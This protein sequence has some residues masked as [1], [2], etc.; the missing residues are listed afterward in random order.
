VVNPASAPK[1][2][3]PQRIKADLIAGLGVEELVT[4][5]FDREFSS[6]TAEEFVR[7]VL[8]GCLAAKL[9]IVGDDFHFGHE[10]R[11]NVSLLRAMGEELT[12]SWS[13]EHARRWLDR[14]LELDGPLRSARQALTRG[15]DSL[16][17]NPRRRRVLGG[18]ASL[19]AGLTALEHTAVQIRSICRGL[20]DLAEAI[21]QRGQAEPE[22]LVALGRLLVEL[23]SGVAVFGR[24]TPDLGGPAEE[25]TLPIAL[26]IAR[27]HRD[28]LAEL[29]LVDA[30]ADPEL[31]HVQGSL[32]ANVDRLLRELHGQLDP[33]A[34]PAGGA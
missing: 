31:W 14:T 18:T 25:P 5:P 2:L 7:E 28:V 34:H 32:L 13:A 23:G 17:L 4:I 30:R 24:L 33:A 11:G 12:D 10:R 22:L 8:V 21:E 15:E 16:R 19:R 3:Y 1:L 26:E 6:K 27:A 9:V 29:M 20:V